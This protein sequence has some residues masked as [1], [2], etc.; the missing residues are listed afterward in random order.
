MANATSRVAKAF[1]DYRSDNLRHSYGTLSSRLQLYTGAMLGFTTGGYLAKFDDT[2]SL[3]FAGLV[4]D[5]EQYGGSQGPKLPNN[6]NESG[7][8]GDGSLDLDF[9]QVKRFEL[10]ISGVAIT[11]IGKTVYAVDDQ[12]GTLDPSTRTY[13]NPIGTVSQLTFATNPASAVSGIAVVEPF[14]VWPAANV[15]LQAAKWLAATGAQSLY[16]W[17][18]GKTIFIP[19]TAAYSITLPPVA[20]CPAGSRLTF[21]KTSADAFAAT[22]DGD[23]AETIDGGA[24]LATVD[25][26]YD[27]VTLVSTGSEWVVLNRDIT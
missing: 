13:A 21:V 6:G 16:R 18:C 20:G 4:L 9:K 23:G 26:Q 2:Q 7:T 25:G 11:D 3:A 22:L 10:A 19:N 14:Y 8:A 24:T 1:R 12:T 15:Q 17:D 27:C 5:V